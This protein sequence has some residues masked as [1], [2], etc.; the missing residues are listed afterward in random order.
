MNFAPLTACLRA[1]LRSSLPGLAAL[2]LLT[3]PAWGQ[4]PTPESV[5]GYKPGADFHLANY[6]ESLAYFKK[7]AASSN[8]IKLVNV[9]KTSYG[10]EFWMC[11]HLQSGEPGATRPL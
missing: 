11:L 3:A 6:E 1:R 8:R 5:L 2:C 9:G 10:R 4:I 7:L